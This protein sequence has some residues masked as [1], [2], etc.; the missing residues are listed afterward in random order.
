MKNLTKLTFTIL[1]AAIL[2]TACSNED[3]PVTPTD[4]GNGEGDPIINTPR[5]MK[6]Q[7][8]TVTRFPGT[9]PNGDKWDFHI[10]P[11]SPTRRPDI[12]VE[13]SKSG[14]SSYVY[15]SDTREDA[16]L[17]TAYDSYVFTE[18]A[19][20]NGGSLPY[21]VP[22]DQTYIIDLMDD[23]GLSADDWMGSVII[24]PAIHYNNDN[25]TNFHKTLSNSEVTIKIDG[26]WEY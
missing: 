20:S 7:S 24:N 16:I 19:A 3:N 8:I 17:E 6:I 5:Y 9:K 1:L 12:Y 25:A 21:S 11:N 10:F 2:F 15:R 26:R 22:M 4:P 13:L 14:S 23:D 18:P